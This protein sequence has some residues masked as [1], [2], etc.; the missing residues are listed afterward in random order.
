M[1]EIKR[2]KQGQF[3]WA[4]CDVSAE[5]ARSVGATVLKPLHEIPGVGRFAVL[6]DSQGAV[7][8][9]YQHGH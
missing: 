3:S 7:F 1:P 2:Y 8:N 6:R 4:D 9:L 5:K